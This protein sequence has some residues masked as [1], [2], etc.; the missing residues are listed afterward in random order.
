[1]TQ[2]QL[3]N[4]NL[5][6]T[7]QWEQVEA[8]DRAIRSVVNG[9]IQNDN[10]RDDAAISVHKMQPGTPGWI[11]R[12]N[13]E[14][15]PEYYP[16]SAIAA[17]LRLS[18]T[19]GMGGTPV[20]VNTGASWTQLVTLTPPQGTW[21]ATVT[22][23]V[24]GGTNALFQPEWRVDGSQVG[25]DPTVQRPPSSVTPMTIR[26]RVT[27]TGTQ[28]VALGIK[29]VTVANAAFYDIVFTLERT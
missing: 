25:V 20:T 12:I 8:N 29:G 22:F 9:G 24:N 16:V 23:Y 4:T 21:I 2:V 13:P 28:P 27:V 14:G 18:T 26:Q 3:P 15:T 11:Y 5:T 19:A 17:D 10:V 7:A 1:M 6:G